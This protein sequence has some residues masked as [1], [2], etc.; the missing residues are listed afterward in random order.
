M[1]MKNVLIT[2]VAGF[3]GSHLAE[4]LVESA[5]DTVIHGTRRP[6]GST[7][8]VRHFM[9][10]LVLHEVD[11]TDA[12]STHRLI[13]ATRPQ[14]IY[15][16]A[17]QSYVRT[18]WESPEATLQTNL[19]GQAQLLEVIRDL[20]TE[21]YNPP[22]VIAGSAEE[23]GHVS[24]EEVPISEEAPLRP[25][26]PYAVSKIGQDFLGYQYFHTYGLN[27]IRLRVFNHTGPRRPTAFGDSKLAHTIALIEKGLHEPKVTYRDL[28]AVRDFT[29]VRDVV[30]AYALAVEN[31]EPGEV[32]NICS[33]EGTAIGDMY[34]TLLSLSTV[35]DIEVVPDPA[36]PRPS[37]GGIVIGDNTRFVAAT[38]WRPKIPFLGRPLPDFLD[39]WRENI[40][41]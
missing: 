34:E 12:L 11:V 6:N 36:G 39:Y 15:H 13:E 26:S 14:A 2:G 22:V 16:L 31:C 3:V 40:I 1:A 23:Y 18:S 24:T 7:G 29:D 41:A 19:V 27:V 10:K 5:P 35:R 20:R 4:Y 32:Y 21:S 37:D 30:R 9:E 17:A 33:G 28:H 25:L 38:G 8:N